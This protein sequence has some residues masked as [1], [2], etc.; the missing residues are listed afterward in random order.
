ML[1]D[2]KRRKEY[3]EAR[4]LFGAGGRPV[5]AT[6]GPAAPPGGRRRTFDLGDLFGGQTGAGGRR[7]R[8]RRPARRAVRR[9]AHRAAATAGRAAGADVETEVT[10]SFDEAVDGVTVPLRMTSER[11]CPTCRGTGRQGRAPRRASARP[12]RAPARPAATRAASPSPSR[13]ATAAAA[14]WSSTTR[15]RPARA[16]AGP[17]APARSRCASRPASRTASGSGS[18]AR[19]RPGERGGPAGDLYVVVHVDAA[20]GVRPQGRQPDPHRAGHLRRGGARRRGQGADPRRDAGHAEDPGRAPP[21]GRTFR[22]RGK[23]VARKDG[24]RATCSSPSRS[25][26][27][28]KLDARGAQGASRSSATRPRARTRAPA[29]SQ[30]A[31]AT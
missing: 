4:A 27:R 3:D 14:G 8:A 10:L 20:P 2:T 5:P 15:A 16:A 6:P 9:H 18:R 12:A 30:R 21:N 19:A 26:C 24:T 1:S 25:P 31:K 7:R 17:R 11:P 28:S 13:A 22:V 23:G 29:C